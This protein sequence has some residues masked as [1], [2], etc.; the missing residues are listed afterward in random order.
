MAIIEVI[1]IKTNI[2]A[3]RAAIDN[4]IRADI[5]QDNYGLM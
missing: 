2:R 3:D 5:K 1:A 4:S